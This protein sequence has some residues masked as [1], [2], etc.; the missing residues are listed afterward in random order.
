MIIVSESVTQMVRALMAGL[1]VSIM[2]DSICSATH[3]EGGFMKTH[4]SV[5]VRMAVRGSRGD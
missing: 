2:A 1:S 5:V 3:V 4:A